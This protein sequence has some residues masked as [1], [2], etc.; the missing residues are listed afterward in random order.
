[1]VQP[2]PNIYRQL[3]HKTYITNTRQTPMVVNIRMHIQYS[4]IYTHIQKG[5][6]YLTHRGRDKM[7]TILQTTFW[8]FFNENARLFD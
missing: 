3:A 1:M 5:G 6:A 4:L 2:Q 7:A 8:N